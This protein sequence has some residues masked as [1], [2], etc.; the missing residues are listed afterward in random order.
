M[1]FTRKKFTF[2]ELRVTLRFPIVFLVI[3][4]SSFLL[5]K[6]TSFNFAKCSR[7]G[8]EDE[9]GRAEYKGSYPEKLYTFA[10]KRN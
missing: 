4:P 2:L 6:I 1:D 3:L 7:I 5:L 10:N 9:R 8:N